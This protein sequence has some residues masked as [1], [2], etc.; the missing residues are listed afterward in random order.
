MNN[1]GDILTWAKLKGSVDYAPSQIGTLLAA[2]GA[3][4]DTEVGEFAAIP[5]ET[6]LDAIATVWQYS[7]SNESDDGQDT[8][9]NIRPTPILKGR[10]VSAHYAARIWCGVETTRAHKIRRIVDEGDKIL[11]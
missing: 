11:S 6:F 10:A 4:A 1:L 9:P 7:A 2:L 3:E 8:D 5:R